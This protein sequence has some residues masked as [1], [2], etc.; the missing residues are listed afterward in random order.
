MEETNEYLNNVVI[1]E[2]EEFYQGMEEGIDHLP[3][4]DKISYFLIQMGED[5]TAEVL[6]HLK[7]EIVREVSKKLIKLKSID[8]PQALKILEEFNYIIQSNQ[9]I[10]SGGL[11]YASDVLTKAFGGPESKRILDRLLKSINKHE[12]FAFLNQ[13]KPQQLAEFIQGE[14]AQTIAIVLAH[15]DTHGAAET[16]SYLNADLKIE[17]AIRMSN[18]KDI[19]PSIVKNIS[20]LLEN[21]LTLLTSSKVELGG[22]RSVAEIFNKMGT[23]AQDTLDLIGMYDEELAQEIKDKMFTFEDIVKIEPAGIALIKDN[24]D[25]ET[26]QKA[27]KNASETIQDAFY[28]VMTEKEK[29]IFLEDMEYIGKLRIKDIDESQT[30]VLIEAQ[31]LIDNE[32]I[33]FEEDE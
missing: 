23:K 29:Q 13:I 11:D 9:Y 30:T 1:D 31:K 8:K 2:G 4:L 20:I 12:S 14:N 33:F 32:Q 28:S 18:L 21:K 17:V 6:L 19:S 25:S 24:I 15:M 5:F 27:I 10:M 22:V 7:P 3:M 26:L 16:L